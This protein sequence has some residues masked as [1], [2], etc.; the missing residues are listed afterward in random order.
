MRRG[1]LPKNRAAR[2]PHICLYSDCCK[3]LRCLLLVLLFKKK[4]GSAYPLKD[5]SFLSLSSY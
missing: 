2:M 1:H 3:V 5:P 4:G